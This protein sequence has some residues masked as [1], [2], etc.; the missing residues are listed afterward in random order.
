MGRT[1]G[2]LA[3]SPVL[4]VLLVAL[5]AFTFVLPA[6]AARAQQLAALSRDGNAGQWQAAIG[7]IVVGGGR[8]NCTATLIT[9]ETVLTAAHCLNHD[10]GIVAPS[11]IVFRPGTQCS[12][13]ICPATTG[14]GVVS[15]VALGRPVAN[16]TI[17]LSSV[18]DDWAILRL[19]RPVDAIRPLAMQVHEPAAISEVLGAGGSLFSAGY[20]SGRFASLKSLKS[21]PF[22]VPSAVF[23]PR[24][25]KVMVMGCHV[26]MGDSGSPI[27]LVGPDGVPAIVGVVS[28]NGRS[29]ALKSGRGLILIEPR[30]IV[31]G[32]SILNVRI[33]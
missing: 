15:V 32:A 30:D 9:P 31:V 5:L 21:C 28:G 18:P 29:L 14:T 16:G 2:T 12:S 33:D 27:I 19:A 3:A 25:Y 17:K 1:S 11:D 6:G 8:Q 26:A 22:L 24:S 20:G 7:L 13:G 4:P 10:G 23:I